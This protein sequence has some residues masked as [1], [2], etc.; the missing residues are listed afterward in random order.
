MQLSFVYVYVLRSV[1]TSPTTSQEQRNTAWL[2]LFDRANTQWIDR[3]RWLT[4]PKLDSVNY[5]V[6]LVIDDQ[7]LMS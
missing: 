4:R 2:I 1:I 6:L 3:L 7:R 5:D